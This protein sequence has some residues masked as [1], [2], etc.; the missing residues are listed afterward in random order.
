MKFSIII[1]GA[2]LAFAAHGQLVIRDASSSIRTSTGT[3]TTKVKKRESASTGTT[4]T[5]S[6]S[7]FTKLAAPTVYP[8]GYPLCGIP[9][10][11]LQPGPGSSTPVIHQQVGSNVRA[12]VEQC[13]AD[14]VDA[15]TGRGQCKSVLFEDRYT[16]CLFYGITVEETRQV[17][18]GRFRF[19]S[20]DKD[21]YAG[22]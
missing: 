15:G 21:C 6:Y 18:D 7:P 1:L 10:A 8:H 20:W 13:R 12:C 17:D 11:D 22:S 14:V 16:M 5:C 19:R 9:N 2:A 4:S 3:I